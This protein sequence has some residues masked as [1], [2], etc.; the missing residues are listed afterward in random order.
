MPRDYNPDD[1]RYSGPMDI[2][3]IFA[4]SVRDTINDRR[5]AQKDQMEQAKFQADMQQQAWENEN[6]RP[7]KLAEARLQQQTQ[8]AQL[9]SAKFKLEAERRGIATGRALAHTYNA[10]EEEVE[11]LLYGPQGNPKGPVLTPDGSYG[12]AYTGADVSDPNDPA[13]K[14]LASSVAAGESGGP[15]PG[16]GPDTLANQSDLPIAPDPAAA[17]DPGILLN[18]QTPVAP[19]P[20]GPPPAPKAMPE[21]VAPPVAASNTDAAP[22]SSPIVR[23]ALQQRETKTRTDLEASAHEANYQKLQTLLQKRAQLPRNSPLKAGIDQFQANLLGDPKFQGWVKTEQEKA[24]TYEL[25]QTL[26]ATI[27]YT[28]PD[29]ARVFSAYYPTFKF[30]I[31]EP[32]DGSRPTMVDAI[33]GNPFP[34]WKLKALKQA[35]DGFQYKPG[36]PLPPRQTPLPGLGA[37]GLTPQNILMVPNAAAPATQ[38]AAAP[39][40]FQE[41][42]KIRQAENPEVAQWDIAKKSVLKTIGGRQSIIRAL[43]ANDKPAT[44]DRLKAVIQSLLADKAAPNGVSDG[45][46]ADISKLEI[47]ILPSSA[48]D[49]WQVADAL[50]QDLWRESQTQTTSAGLSKEK[51]DQAEAFPIK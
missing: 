40:I 50:A 34:G 9:D 35:W 14:E 32:M 13:L 4:D 16:E 26:P 2:A 15:M 19:N 44:L 43:A 29:K 48:K 41:A 22:S 24:E 37:P 38:A 5:N 21:P 51:K 18:P 25:Q 23:Q 7:I 47:G 27:A 20:S 1:G 28:N 12:S 17:P 42:Q 6:V 36:M 3:N 31:I 11:A 39:N 8:Q 45:E 10:A 49:H 46:V 30:T 33:T